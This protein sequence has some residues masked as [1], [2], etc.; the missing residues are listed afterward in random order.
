MDCPTLLITF[1][2]EQGGHGNQEKERHGKV[3]DHVGDVAA[4]DAGERLCR[5]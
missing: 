1:T 4:G 3:G 5:S 2:G